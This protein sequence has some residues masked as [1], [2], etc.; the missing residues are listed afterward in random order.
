MQAAI[1]RTTQAPIGWDGCQHCSHEETLDVMVEH[2]DMGRLMT[3][4]AYDAEGLTRNGN[5]KSGK[6]KPKDPTATP[7]LTWVVVP[8]VEPQVE[9]APVSRH[10]QRQMV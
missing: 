1:T 4:A 9:Q 10:P 3:L 6:A 5:A 2:W 7:N 8:D